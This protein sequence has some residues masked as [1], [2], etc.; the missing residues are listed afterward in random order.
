LVAHREV[1]KKEELLGNLS[2]IGPQQ[3]ILFTAVINLEW[4]AY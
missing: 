2:L 1:E 4:I 3:L